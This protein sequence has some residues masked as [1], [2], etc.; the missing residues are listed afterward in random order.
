M[1]DKAS[2]IK[3]RRLEDRVRGKTDWGQVD[4]IT[5]DEIETAITGDKDAAPILTE[6]FWRG[7]EMVMPAGAKERITL[8]VD[9]DVLSYFRNQGR[10]Y[11]TRINAVLRAFVRE[12]QGAD[13]R[14]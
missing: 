6:E 4:A 12:R 9:E 10:G 1:N 2:T 3:R 7:A 8:R 14:G 11:Q 5:D 13:R